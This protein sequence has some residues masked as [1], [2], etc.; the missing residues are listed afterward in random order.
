MIQIDA[1]AI[2][3]KGNNVFITG[4]PGTGKS[5]LIEQFIKKARRKGRHVAI[6]ASSG[7][8]ASL[9]GGITVQSWSGLGYD[10]N[11]TP[12]RIDKLKA[13]PWLI[14]RL[15][16]CDILIIDEISM[17]S[18]TFFSSLDLLIR[19]IRED[20]ESF[21]GIQVVLSGDFFQLPPVNNPS[22]SYIFNTE[23]WHSLDLKICY[24]DQQYRQTNDELLF[25]LSALRSQQFAAE[26]LK[27][28]VA[29][30]KLNHQ[31]C[32]ALMTHNRDVELRNELRLA[33]LK[34][35]QRIFQMVEE[36]RAEDVIQL[37]RGLLAPEKLHLKQGA[38]VMFTAND[39]GRG[40]VNGTQGEVVGFKKDL[41]IVLLTNGEKLVVEPRE[42]RYEVEEKVRARVFQLP[43]R[44]AWAVTIHK[45]QGMSLAMAEIDLSRSFAYGMGYVALSRLK[46]YHGLFLVGLN[47]R[48][49][50]LDPKVQ[51]FDKRLRE[52]N[53]S[54]TE[55]Y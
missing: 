53:L 52:G 31:P 41:P 24:L 22:G 54:P 12:E 25:L 39:F 8:A 46:S 48:S 14:N 21:G 32:T 3:L 4:S 51:L 38:V 13:N 50:E 19:S 9:I 23:A 1:L 30:Q 6:T 37:K 55:Q 47:S 5:Y 42:W 33:E 16:A 35:K 49:L 44:L 45:S 36:G 11:L 43:L 2:L 26:H 20:N 40:Y 29:R 28:L 34:T 18:A 10:E 27:L 17:L 15:E 7:I